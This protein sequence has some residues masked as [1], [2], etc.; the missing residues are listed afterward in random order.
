MGG[1]YLSN[2]QPCVPASWCQVNSEN[3]V[4]MIGWKESRGERLAE[5]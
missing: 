5:V 3:G 2:G 1:T 4:A